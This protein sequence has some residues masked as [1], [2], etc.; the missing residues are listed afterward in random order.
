VSGIEKDVEKY[1]ARLQEAVD[2]S[3]KETPFGIPSRALALLLLEGD[4]EFIEVVRHSLNGEKILEV[5]SI[6]SKEMEEAYG[7]PAG[8]RI[9]R[10]RHRLAGAISESVQTEFSMKEPLSEKLKQYTVNVY[11][12]IPIML[13]VLMGVFVFVSTVGQALSSLI[14]S[15]W[16]YSASPLITALLRSLVRNPVLENILRWGQDAGIL[17]MLSVGVAYILPFY[18]VLSILEDSGY[19]NSIAFLVDS[20]MH[21]FGLHGRAI[22]PLITGLGCNVPAIMGTRVLMTKRER[23]LAS[24]LIVLVP[25]SARI[26]V[27]LGA[28]SA[29]LGLKY[30]LLIYRVDF[31][32]IALVGIGLNR[33]LPGKSTGLVMEMFPFRFPSLSTTVKKTWF[34][35]R[36]F[37]RVALPITLFGSFFMGA[38]FETGYL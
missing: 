24:T 3:L 26:A 5:S 15:A 8:I 12:G 36:D 23:I 2:E 10:E 13:A 14:V 37:V 21:R 19:L 30:A 25:C 20:V 9:A 6:L 31:L 29:F 35:L 38:L 18:V 11:T 7:E 28:V 22:I 34:R 32:L 27:I 33:V 17:S 1:V 16:G 4:V